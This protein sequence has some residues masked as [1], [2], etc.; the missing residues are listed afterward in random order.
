MT[1]LGRPFPVQSS[2][3]FMQNCAK[4]NENE[5]IKVRAPSPWGPKD[6]HTHDLTQTV[7]FEQDLSLIWEGFETALTK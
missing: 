3:V 4:I 2:T 6:P 1:F 5:H 7:K